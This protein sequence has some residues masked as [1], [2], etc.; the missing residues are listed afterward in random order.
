VNGDIIMPQH[1]SGT[2][3]AAVEECFLRPGD[4][5]PTSTCSDKQ[6]GGRQDKRDARA[7][8]QSARPDSIVTGADKQVSAG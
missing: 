2:Q 7:D 4:V 8:M 1:P 6:A 3:Q 5:G